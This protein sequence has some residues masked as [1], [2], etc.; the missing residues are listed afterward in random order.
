ME[1]QEVIFEA[2]VTECGV[3]IVPVTMTFRS[4]T[5]RNAGLSFFFSKD[6]VA[7]LII[8]SGECRIFDEKGNEVSP[9]DFIADFP[10][11]TAQVKEWI[12]P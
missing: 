12:D 7:V 10:E 2:P 1:K 5:F 8:Q 6:P 4:G 11:N 9:D 3:T